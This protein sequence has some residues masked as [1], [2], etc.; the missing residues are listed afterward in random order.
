MYCTYALMPVSMR[1]PMDQQRFIKSFYTVFVPY[2]CSPQNDWPVPHHD[3]CTACVHH[4]R[5][6]QVPIGCCGQV[7]WKGVEHT[8]KFGVPVRV[9]YNKY[10][11]FL[12]KN[13]TP[14]TCFCRQQGTV[15]PTTYFLHDMRGDPCC[16]Q[17]E[18]CLQ[19]R[20]RTRN[21]R[22]VDLVPP[23]E[24]K[25]IGRHCFEF[26]AFTRI[27]PQRRS[28]NWW[29]ICSLHHMAFGFSRVWRTVHHVYHGACVQLQHSNQLR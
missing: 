26:K 14:R 21:A 13:G 2:C 1:A 22:R 20:I 5:G 16:H 7:R 12:L 17:K 25:T 11:L 28:R 19:K 15:S 4:R 24:R 27:L 9:L 8:S 29:W 18:A 6:R 23:F 3:L 10:Y